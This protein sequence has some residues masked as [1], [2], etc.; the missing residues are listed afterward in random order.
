MAVGVQGVS[1]WCSQSCGLVLVSPVRSRDLDSMIAW[2]QWWVPSNLRYSMILWLEWKS[3]IPSKYPRTNKAARWQKPLKQCF[4]TSEINFCFLTLRIELDPERNAEFCISLCCGKNQPPLGSVSC[5]SA[6]PW[7]CAVCYCQMLPPCTCWCTWAER[8]PHVLD[9][10][11]EAGP[12]TP[13][14]FGREVAV[15]VNSPWAPVNIRP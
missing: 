4:C 7:E 2:A 13:N 3:I 10:C 11:C 12:V 6:F 1:G 5:S 9:Q 14:C 8:G 15:S